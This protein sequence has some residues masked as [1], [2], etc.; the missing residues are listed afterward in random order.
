M[1]REICRDVNK[2]KNINRTDPPNN[3]PRLEEYLK[4][5]KYF[6]LHMDRATAN[7]LLTRAFKSFF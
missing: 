1:S 3:N 4:K 7:M 6:K 5:L 2:T